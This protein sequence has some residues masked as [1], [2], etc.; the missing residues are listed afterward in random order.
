MH[1]LDPSDPVELLTGSPRT[2]SHPE[3]F[4]SNTLF[5]QPGLY[6]DGPEMHPAAPPAFDRDESRATLGDLLAPD[7]VEE[8]EG[9]FDDPALI[10]RVPDDA[11]RA[12]LLLLGDGPSDPVLRAFLTGDT[13][14]HSFGIDRTAGAGRVI[15]TAVGEIEPRRRVLNERYRSEH[16][17]VIAPSLAHA[18]C[19]HGDRA[20]NA[21]EAT[22]HGLLA[23]THVWLLAGTPALV[24]L[25][26][27]LA[28]RQASMSITLLNARPPG[29]AA[30]SIRCPDG[31]GTIPGGNP[32]LQSPDLWSIPFTTRDDADCALDVPK[33][34]RESLA[35]LAAATAPA[36]PARYDSSLG[37]WLTEHCGH[38]AWFGPQ[39]RAD[40]GRALGLFGPDPSS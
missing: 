34:V 12:A 18:L 13:A 10:E 39:V 15:G 29:G 20:S 7:V 24:E 8:A 11:V 16:P 32:V 19:H 36:V 31:P 26:T 30:A 40:A 25:G 33:P 1:S 4:S 6:P 17:A 35:R 23:A 37:D 5:G 28:R 14:V 2:P 22:L 3:Y 9:R 21:E 38:G 27:E